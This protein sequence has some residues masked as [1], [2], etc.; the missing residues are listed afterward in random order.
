MRRILTGK[1]ASGKTTDAIGRYNRMLSDR[2][3]S[4]EILVL[5]SNRWEKLRWQR[6]VRYQSAGSLNIYSYFGFVQNEIRIYWPLILE[7][8]DLIKK[9]NPLP[10]IMQYEA[11]QSLMYKTVEYYRKKGYLDGIISEDEAIA[12]KLL[13]NI[14]GAALSNT[15]YRKMGK[16]IYLSKPSEGRFSEKFY[17]QMNEIVNRYIERT[18]EEGIIDQAAAIYLYSNYLLKDE[19]YLLQLKEK[20]K[21]LIVDDL[22]LASISQTDFILNLCQWI[23]GVIL[24]KNEDGPYGIYQFSKDYMEEKLIPLFQKEGIEADKKSGFEELLEDFKGSL[25]LE[26]G[27]IKKYDRVHLDIDNEYKSKTDRKI[28]RLVKKLLDEGV[29][30][31]EI[32]VVVPRYD[33]TLDFGLG[34]IAR[35]RKINYL[36]TSKNDKI[37]DNPRVFSLIV[38][39]LLFYDFK[40]IH[41]NYDEVKSFLSQVLGI[42]MIMSSILA[43]HLSGKNYQIK[44]VEKKG[45]IRGVPQNIID[46]LNKVADFIGEIPKDIPIDKFFLSVY[47]EF[48]LEGEGN[49][50]DIKAC[51]SL[52][53]SATSFLEVMENFGM[54]K[55]ANYEF[56][57]FIR[58]GAKTTETLDDIGEK[59]EGNFLSLS[60][61][62]SFIGTKRRGRY[63]IMTDIKNPLY[64][65]KTNNEFQNLWSLN[66]NWKGEVLTGEMELQ[67]EKEELYAVVSRM[68]RSSEELYIFGTIFSSRGYEQWSVFSEAVDKTIS[69]E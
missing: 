43:D 27:R 5:V 61:P 64:T 60:T 34:K 6:E 15:N 35:D 16:R 13:S 22:E 28:L 23:R 68:I 63:L 46:K 42:N 52:M 7:K 37:T 18:L 67:K 56:V 21:F 32:S 12:R 49:S 33:V 2:I 19:R 65:L 31:R 38:F 39:A 47:M 30:P 50:E 24:Y 3:N 26:R 29:D 66:K 53:D 58:E 1:T 40:K 44:R 36:Y 41:V 48:L 9:K 62:G 14:V 25:F 59:L 51:K 4:N 17:E 55:N 8:C 54:I 69:G 45:E 10:V 20:Y 57:K 11:S